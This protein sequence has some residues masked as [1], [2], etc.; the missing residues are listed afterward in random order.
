M[1]QALSDKI[2]LS[3]N[4]C[5]FRR[6]MQ[7][8]SGHYDLAISF[9]RTDP[10]GCSSLLPKQDAFSLLLCSR[11]ILS[12]WNSWT[13]GSLLVL[14]RPIE[15]A[16]VTG[17][18]QFWHGTNR[19]GHLVSPFALC[20]QSEELDDMTEMDLGGLTNACRTAFRAAGNR[21]VMPTEVR[22]SLEQLRFPTRT[23]KN[24]LASVHT[25]IRRLERA[26]EIRKAIHHKYLGEDKSVYQWAGANYGASTSLANQMADAERDR[27]R[28]KTQENSSPVTSP[29][30]I[31]A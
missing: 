11:I 29:V 20:Q 24:I 22:D 15:T 2:H 5:R 31:P 3:V 4:G 6:S 21:G 1:L 9:K 26:G 27:L 8:P 7:H 30:R 28:R 10:L 16:G 17:R 18:V 19:Q 12:P 25:V 23:H 13:W 14:H